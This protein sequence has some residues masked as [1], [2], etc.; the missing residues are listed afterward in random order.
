MDR[1]SS[2]ATATTEL[3]LRMTFPPL[4][5][6]AAPAPRDRDRLFGRLFRFLRAREGRLRRKLGGKGEPRVPLASALRARA[7]AEDRPSPSPA[8][9]LPCTRKTGVASSAGHRRQACAL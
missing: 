1:P 9:P 5:R 7:R 8:R 3:W 4:V 2:T 6:R